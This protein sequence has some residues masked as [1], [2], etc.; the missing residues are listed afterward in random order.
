MINEITKSEGIERVHTT[1]KDVY[2]SMNFTKIDKLSGII[3]KYKQITEKKLI[4]LRK[5]VEY[6][7]KFLVKKF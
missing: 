2:N 4:Q 6:M 1:K 5:Y 7:M 3:K